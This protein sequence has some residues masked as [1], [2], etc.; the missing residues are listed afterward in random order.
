MTYEEFKHAV[1]K[2]V[3][4]RVGKEVNVTVRQ[5]PKNN[6]VLLDGITLMKKGSYMAPTFYLQ[7]FYAA[8]QKGAEL[9]EIIRQLI[10]Y[11]LAHP[12]QN[13]VPNDFFIDYDGVKDQICFKVVHY[14]KNK[15]FLEEVPHVCV[16]DLAIVF[17]CIVKEEYM[18]QASI[19]IRH[20]DLERWGISAKELFEQ[21]LENTPKKL[22]WRFAPIQSVVDEL[23]TKGTKEA[24]DT[25]DAAKE[26]KRTFESA[27]EM[28]V[29]TNSNRYY[30][31]ACMLYPGLLA[32]I[33]QKFESDLYVL[34]SSIHECIIM[35]VNKWYTKEKLSEIVQEINE[36]EVECLDVLSDLVY[37]Y[38]R[39]LNELHV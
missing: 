34:P 21:A 25:I 31:A 6:G 36:K 37:Y 3:E 39:K 12:I 14:E 33:A 30:G 11:S 17:Y 27:A 16:L 1:M 15:K 7:D 32:K 2:E 35:P 5:V 19:L 28:Y 13:M 26:I 18:S 23:I 24:L 8:L 29:L 9:E 20:P 38:D 4:H 22:P 10:G